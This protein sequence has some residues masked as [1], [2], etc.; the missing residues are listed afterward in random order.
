MAITGIDAYTQAL[1]AQQY[2]SQVSAGMGGSIGGARPVTPEK[3]E[4]LGKESEGTGKF[5]WKSLNQFD[6]TVIG[7]TPKTEVGKTSEVPN[8][9]P[10]TQGVTSA[11]EQPKSGLLE[12]LNRIDARDIGLNSNKNGMDGQRFINI[13]A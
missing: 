4:G 13:M 10:F 11:Y 1:M 3:V 7:T 8:G 2:G 6:G 12:A 9:N 5:N